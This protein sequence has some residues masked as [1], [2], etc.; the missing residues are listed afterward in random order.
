MKK[1]IQVIALGAIA[2]ALALPVLAKAPALRPALFQAAQDADAKAALYKRVTDNIKANPQVAYEAAK[3]YL[4]KYPADNDDITNY[5]KKYI[6]AYDKASR[7]GKLDQLIKDQKYT[8]AFTLGKQVLA[9]SPDNLGTLLN[10]A[11]AGLNLTTSGNHANDAEAAEFSRRTIQLLESGKTPEEG[12]PFPGKDEALGWLNY[13]LALY[14]LNNKRPTEAASFLIKAAQTE[15][16]IKKDP[17]VYGQLAAVYESEYARLSQD[18][19]T[20]FEGKPESPESKTAY[21]QVK[22]FVDPLIDAYARAVAYSGTQAQYQK[23]K[24]TWMQR[25]TELYQF[26]NGSTTNLN[27]L[28][29][30]VTSKPLPPQPSAA[31]LPATPVTTTTQ[32][33]TSGDNTKTST[34]TESSATPGGTTPATPAEATKGGATTAQPAGKT[35]TTTKTTT[36]TTTTKPK[37]TTGTPR[38]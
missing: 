18:F 13:S 27:A 25:L 28:V 22:Q 29:A 10:V 12:K 35:T 7:G 21:D 9:D 31:P 33:P 24:A 34:P 15:G 19:K 4:A 3:E 1:M 6:A 38:P 23:S 8:D 5:L 17:R 2:A 37:T 20:R 30:G 11:W 32:P 14:S 16:F 36:K 26:R